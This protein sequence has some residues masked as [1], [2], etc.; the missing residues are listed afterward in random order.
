MA[1]GTRSK[2][3]DNGQ[4]LWDEGFDDIFVDGSFATD[5]L[6]PGDIDGYFVCQKPEEVLD[7]D[8]EHEL[9]DRLNERAK[10]R[11]WTWRNKDR[12]RPAEAEKGQLPMWFE[13]HVEMWPEYGQWSG[14]VHP[15]TNQRLTHSELFRITKMGEEKGI[16]KLL[17]E[18]SSR[19]QGN[20]EN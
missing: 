20:D 19:G 1:P 3:T 14:Q 12:R 13:Y 18:Q 6:R 10:V 7:S 4:H 15:L 8:F 11:V 9:C 5:K 16:I 17:R 2:S